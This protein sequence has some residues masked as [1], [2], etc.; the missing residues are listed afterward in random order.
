MTVSDTALEAMINGQLKPNEV[1]DPR[2]LDAIR[3]VPRDTFVPKARRGYAY[4]DESLEVR[5]GRYLLSPMVFAHMLVAAGVKPTDMVLDIGGVSGYSAAVLSHLAEAVVALEE[6]DAMVEM[7]EGKLEALDIVNVAAM[8]GPLAAGAPK[9]AP[10]DVIL[11]Q[12]AVEE[13]P[14]ALLK[15]LG[16][17]GRLVAV[18]K[19]TAAIGRLVVYT[20]HGGLIG[21]RV[22]SD[23]DAPALPG[24]EK[25]TAF[26]F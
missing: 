2:I 17:G 21:D 19:E 4:V 13:V 9:Q 11:L 25:A 14:E 23:A 6:S 24:F 20:K 1:N 26:V 15:Q 22:L 18:L 12:G 16:D 10:F 8:A 7:M 5:D 3:A